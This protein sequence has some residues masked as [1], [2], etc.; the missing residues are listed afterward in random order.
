MENEIKVVGKYIGPNKIKQVKRLGY[1]TP[2]GSPVYS[3]E[4]KDGS[5]ELMTSYGLVSSVSDAP[6]DLTAL[7]DA[8]LRVVAE[9]VLEVMTDYNLK[10]LDIEFLT[11]LLANSI[12]NSLDKAEEIAIG[13]DKYKRTLIHIDNVLRGRKHE[14]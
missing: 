13:V 12:N 7:R 1:T 10:V 8:V 14:V 11:S 3:V 9:K 5:R 2:S 6:R 4:Y